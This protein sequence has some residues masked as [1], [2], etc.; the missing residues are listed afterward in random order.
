MEGRMEGCPALFIYDLQLVPAVQRKGL[1]K[2]LMQVLEMIARKQSMSYIMLPAVT[3][4]ISAH[5]FIEMLATHGVFF[6][7]GAVVCVQSK[8]RGFERDSE[9]TVESTH[10]MWSKNVQPTPRT[11]EPASQGGPASPNLPPSSPDIT[12]THYTLRTTPILAP[13]RIPWEKPPLDP[14]WTP[15][16]P[17]LDPLTKG[18]LPNGL[19]CALA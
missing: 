5:R 8:L 11:P 7:R 17:P 9:Y 15:S 3:D 6:S 1:G 10:Q 18:K 12:T 13:T 4:C 2:H 14:L 16:G 19:P